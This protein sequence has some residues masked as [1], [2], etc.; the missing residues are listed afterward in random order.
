MRH[1]A[2]VSWQGR[3]EWRKKELKVWASLNVFILHMYKVSRSISAIS[4]YQPSAH[5]SKS[6]LKQA[7]KSCTLHRYVTPALLGCLLGG[8]TVYCTYMIV[9]WRW[10]MFVREVWIMCIM[11]MYTGD[12]FGNFILSQ[13]WSD[14]TSI[15]TFCLVESQQKLPHYLMFFT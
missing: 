1:P 14:Y 15:L 5:H 10:M 9:P 8:Y 11:Y 2:W 13:I 12:Q 4:I 7:M 3:V 6:H